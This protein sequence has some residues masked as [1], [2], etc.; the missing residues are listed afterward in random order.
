MQR[1]F[2]AAT[3]VHEKF[4]V[5]LKTLYITEYEESENGVNNARKVPESK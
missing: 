1:T 5:Q 2:Q 4:T 3:A